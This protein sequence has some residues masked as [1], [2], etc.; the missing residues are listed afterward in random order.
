LFILTTLFLPRGIVGVFTWGPRPRRR[1]E[2]AVSAA[3]REVTG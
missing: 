3:A 2:P 1:I